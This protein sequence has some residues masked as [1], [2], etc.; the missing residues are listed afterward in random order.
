MPTPIDTLSNAHHR[1]L[2][3]VAVATQALFAEIASASEDV[4]LIAAMTTLNAQLAMIRPY[5]A[6]F[7]EDRDEELAALS[8]SWARRDMTRLRRLVLTYFQRRRDIVPQLV[9]L[10]N[11]PN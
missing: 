10:I 6:A 9:T 2:P 11:N 5:E 8:E 4:G 3:D 7:I 1:P